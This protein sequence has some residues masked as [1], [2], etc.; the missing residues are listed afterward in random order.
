MLPAGH[1]SLTFS[2]NHH[3]FYRSEILAQPQF[4]HKATSTSTVVRF[5]TATTL[6]KSMPDGQTLLVDNGHDV[7]CLTK[8]V[9]EVFVSETTG[10]ICPGIIFCQA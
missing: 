5:D 7:I 3:S 4:S 2:R 1:S 8:F 6:R 9:L 10:N